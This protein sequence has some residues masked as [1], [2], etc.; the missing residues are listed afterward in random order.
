MVI[1]KRNDKC[2]KVNGFISSSHIQSKLL[3]DTVK[4]EIYVIPVDEFSKPC[5]QRVDMVVTVCWIFSLVRNRCHPDFS[6][7]LDDAESNLVPDMGCTLGDKTIPI[8]ILKDAVWPSC[9]G[10]TVTFLESWIQVWAVCPQVLNTG[11]HNS[12]SIL[13]EMEK[14]RPIVKTL[15]A[16]F[17]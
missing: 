8:E 11:V 14:W 17:C 10:M 5:C 6:P 4:I 15:A 2:E 7:V 12:A 1:T 13:T 3:F 16:T 9:P